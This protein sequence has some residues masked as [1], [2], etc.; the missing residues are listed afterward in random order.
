MKLGYSTLAQ[1]TKTQVFAPTWYIHVEL[2][3]GELED[4]FINAIDGKIIEFQS[5]KDRT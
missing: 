3:S 4:Y 5:E 1:L 2:S